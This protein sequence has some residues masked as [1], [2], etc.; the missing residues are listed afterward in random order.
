MS[1][2]SPYFLPQPRSAITPTYLFGP[3]SPVDLCSAIDSTQMLLKGA[4]SITTTGIELHFANNV[5]LLLTQERLGKRPPEVHASIIRLN[6][7]IDLFFDPPPAPAKLMLYFNDGTMA[8]NA[9]AAIL[10]LQALP[11]SLLVTSTSAITTT[12]T[13]NLTATTTA[14]SITT[15]SVGI[16]AVLNRTHE[17]Q[18]QE[19][20][21]A[22]DAFADL[23]QLMRRAEDVLGVI[24]RY[25]STM[26]R[27]TGN[28]D[29]TE[30]FNKLLQEIGVI[31]NPVTKQKS[32]T[33]TG[34]QFHEELA[35]Q[36][37]HFLKLKKMDVATLPDVYAIYNRA[38]GG[39]DLV[40]PQDV[41]LACRKMNE[42]KEIDY[43]LIEYPTTGMKILRSKEIVS[44]LHQQAKS[45]LIQHGVSGHE[46]SKAADVPLSVAIEWLNAEEQNT[47][48]AR[49]VDS[50]GNILWY[51]NL[52]V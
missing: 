45:L 52:F 51:E 39:F 29:E 31:E 17:R 37:A 15:P 22:R 10:R 1:F 7:R 28:T 38:R 26:N 30:A 40:S 18:A 50:W 12:T 44:R 20:A 27:N 5:R 49:D 4:L 34:G 46:L 23:D 41:L 42:I 11:P 25:S 35:Q 13:T 19:S 48:L 47:K 33:T 24:Q 2:A 6:P 3:V 9:H 21:L 8:K 36:I 32:N 16:Q 43:E 14:T